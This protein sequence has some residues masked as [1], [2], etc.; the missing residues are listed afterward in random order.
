MKNADMEAAMEEVYK[1]IERNVDA[2]VEAGADW[3][4]CAS[5]EDIAAAKNG[6]IKL[7]LSGNRET[8][9][10]W[11]INPAADKKVLCLA[12][13]GG[14][15]GPILAAAGYEVTVLDISDQMLEKDRF[16]AQKEG[17]EIETVHGNMCDMSMFDDERFDMI[18]NPP[19]MMYVPDVGP[20]MKECYRVLKKDGVFI[21]IAPS[22]VNYY[23][24]YDKEGGFYKFC[25]R[26]PYKSYEHDE[27]DWIEFGHTMEDY[28]G[29]TIEAGFKITGYY[30]DQY[31]DITELWFCVRAVK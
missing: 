7:K 25:N 12:G 30:E 26:M 28:L 19:S 6:I 4:Q 10:E 18:I 17:L 2:L 16:I 24:D 20:V 13:A 5:N 22:P 15:Q 27:S 11:L 23:C 3:T 31:E 29:K 8:P 21:Y 9:P 14:L 1:K